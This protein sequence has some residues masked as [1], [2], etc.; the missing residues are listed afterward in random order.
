HV[1]PIA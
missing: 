1:G